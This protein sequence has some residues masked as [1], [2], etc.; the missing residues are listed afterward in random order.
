MATHTEVSERA[1]VA[2]YSSEYPE[3]NGFVEKYRDAIQAG[4]RFPDWGYWTGYQDESELAHW[5]PFIKAAA[6]R[7][8]SRY[9][10]DINSPDPAKAEKAGRYAAFVLGLMCHHAADVAWH[11][12]DGFVGIMGHQNFNGSFDDAHQIAD[13]GGDIAC[14]HE[15]DMSWIEDK[16]WVPADDMAE[17][18]HEMGFPDVTSKF[19]ANANKLMFAATQ[20]ETNAGYLLFSIPAGKSTF[21]IDELQ[22]FFMGGLD[23][24]SVWTLW[25]W[26]EAIDWMENGVE[27]DNAFFYPRNSSAETG[28]VSE[29]NNKIDTKGIIVTQDDVA[30]GVMLSLG[31]GAA[32]TAEADV[33]PKARPG[34]FHDNRC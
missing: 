3:Y 21:L 28:I 11:A 5:Y 13:F 16:I 23:D 9:K 14:A 10:Q 6:N 1:S 2:F 31:K 26:E 29:M 27:T 20:A 30:G 24:M 25:R 22:G 19:I 7:F 4:C 17:V 33:A 12:N 18:Y 15:F 32:R 8:N 34:R